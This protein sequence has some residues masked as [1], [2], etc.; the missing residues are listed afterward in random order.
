MDNS[1]NEAYSAFPDRIFAVD[2]GGKIAF[3]ADQGPWGYAP[4]IKD[5]RKWFDKRKTAAAKSITKQTDSK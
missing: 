1:V 3:V 4:A 2:V 5:V